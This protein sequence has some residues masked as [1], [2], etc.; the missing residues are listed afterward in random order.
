MV[1]FCP[2]EATALAQFGPAALPYSEQLA[3]CLHRPSDEAWKAAV[4]AALGAL[5]ATQ[6]NNVLV[7]PGMQGGKWLGLGYIMIYIIIRICICI[8]IGI[9]L[10]IYI[11]NIELCNIELHVYVCCT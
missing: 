4:L 1:S 11:Y 8:C 2:V 6:H 3:T 9:E 5:R 10:Y 7:V